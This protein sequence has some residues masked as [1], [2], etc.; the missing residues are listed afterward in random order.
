[1]CIRDS[2]EAVSSTRDGPFLLLLPPPPCPSASTAPGEGLHGGLLLGS[3]G[4]HR[5][6]CMLNRQNVGV[7]IFPSCGLS[8]RVNAVLRV[9][10]SI[11]LR[12]RRSFNVSAI[13]LDEPSCS[14]RCPTQTSLCFLSRHWSPAGR[15]VVSL[16]Y[17]AADHSN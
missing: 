15:C 1:M 11:L 3:C 9:L 13:G 14:G 16:F 4:R 12:C 2:F 17:A 8:S 10:Q 7:P 5:R 6:R